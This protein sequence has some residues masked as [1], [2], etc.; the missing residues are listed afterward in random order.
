MF[1]LTDVK[2]TSKRTNK[3]GKLAT[4]IIIGGNVLEH[5]TEILYLGRLI[6]SNKLKHFKSLDENCLVYPDSLL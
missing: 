5:K 6:S 1:Q 2:T 3:S 4:L